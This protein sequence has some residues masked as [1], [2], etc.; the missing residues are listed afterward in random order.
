MV[1]SSETPEI[2]ALNSNE[3]ER[4]LTILCGRSGALQPFMCSLNRERL[5]Y[6][7]NSLIHRRL[8]IE[9]HMPGYVIVF[10]GSQELCRSLNTSCP[11]PKADDSARTRRRT[12]EV[13]NLGQER[14]VIGGIS[15]LSTG[16]RKERI[17]EQVLPKAFT[18][19][20][21]RLV[22]HS[23]SHTLVGGPL[24]P[25]YTMRTPMQLQHSPSAACPIN[26]L[27]H[28]MSLFRCSTSSMFGACPA[29][30]ISTTN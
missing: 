30:Q 8:T 7:L 5:H 13:H 28:V 21:G 16:E 1:R 10:G 2:C 9:R 14:K 25:V 6:L 20:G 15:G 12:I 11:R 4:E 27:R 24:V 3:M 29:A 18:L 23:L 17:V 19:V 26:Q 22:S